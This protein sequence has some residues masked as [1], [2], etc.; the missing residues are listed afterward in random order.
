MVIFHSEETSAGKYYSKNNRQ[1]ALN[2]THSSWLSSKDRTDWFPPGDVQE[3]KMKGEC[4]HSGLYQPSGRFFYLTKL[5]E[6]LHH[7]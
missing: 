7:T 1:R 4:L 2:P 6:Y 3:R 5:Y